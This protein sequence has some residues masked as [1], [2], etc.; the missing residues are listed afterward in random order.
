MSD[1]SH[2]V[3]DRE[4]TFAQRVSKLLRG[5]RG[6]RP[7]RLLASRSGGALSSRQLRAFERGSEAPDDTLLL[8]LARVYGFETDELYPVR[9]LLDIDLAE[10]TVGAA[11]V[12]RSFD[13]EDRT[14]L[15]VAYLELVRELRDEPHALTLSLRRDD[16]EILAT[17]LNLDGPIVVERL[18]ALMGS[19]ALQ[20]RVAAAAFSLGRPAIVLPG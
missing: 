18:G 8:A 11:G 12:T 9:T 13:P 3:A 7:R 2:E 14:G 6:H 19:T 16:I 4:P 17:A 20:Q 15:L 5:R 1:V 10:G